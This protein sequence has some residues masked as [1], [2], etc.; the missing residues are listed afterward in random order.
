MG[1]TFTCLLLA[2]GCATYKPAPDSYQPQIARALTQTNGPIVASVSVLNYKEAQKMFDLKLHKKNIQP[3]WLKITNTSTNSY[4]FLPAG[5][6]P[7]YHPPSEVAYMYR[8]FLAGKRNKRVAHHLAVNGIQAKIPPGGSVEGFVFSNYDPGAKHV[9]VDVLGEKEQWRSEFAVFIPGKRFDF[10]KVDFESIYTNQVPDYS[11]AE[12]PAVLEALPFQTTDKRGTGNGDPINL[13]VVTATSEGLTA[14]AF[15]RLNWD[16]TQALTFG[17]TLKL[18]GSFL[19]NDR[20]RTSPV[21]S[22]YLFDRRQ[23]FALQ[24]ARS[25]I[26]ERNHLRLWLAPFTV[27]GKSVWVGQIS[28]DIGLRFTLKAPGFTTH[29]I[30]P[31]TDEARDYLAQ[32]MLLSGSVSSVAWVGGVGRRPKDDPGR[33]LTGDPWWTDGQR[34]VLFLSDEQV[35]PSEIELL[36]WTSPTAGEEAGDELK[37]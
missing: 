1:V 18:V 30:D 21:S 16:L 6:D 14:P 25:T 34:V 35:P 9:V 4:Y 19:F 15:L 2:S 10:E 20:W 5:L 24:K 7:N 26:H 11:M 32:E 8:K 27:V 28:R 23:D 12:L 33:N 17:S 29:K 36:D 37:P 31:E 13:V 22:L 3:V